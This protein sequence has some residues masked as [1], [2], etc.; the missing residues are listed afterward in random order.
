MPPGPSLPLTPSLPPHTLP[1]GER[2][3][4]K[5]R[6]N[7]FCSLP[8]LPER[9]GVRWERRAGEVRGPGGAHNVWHYE[10]SGIGFRRPHNCPEI[11]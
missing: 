3:L 8:P 11:M 6:T 5:A 2:G 9:V 10:N 4:E 7:F 1:P